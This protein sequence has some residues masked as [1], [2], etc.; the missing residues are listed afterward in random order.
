VIADTITALTVWGTIAALF[1]V[2]MFC[3][4]WDK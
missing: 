1:M 2:T 3:L 4:W